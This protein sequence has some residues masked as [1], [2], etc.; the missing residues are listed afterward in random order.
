M[1]DFLIK[2]YSS[3]VGF[4]RKSLLSSI[5]E[6]ENF[7]TE[8]VPSAAYLSALDKDFAVLSPIGWGEVC[9][10]DFE[11]VLFGKLLIKPSM[12][13]IQTWPNIYT[14]NTCYLLNWDF[15]ELT[16]LNDPDYLCSTLNFN[17]IS[18]SRSVYLSSL[19][20]LNQRL[21]DLLNSL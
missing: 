8:R 14:D 4:Q 16:Q 9:Y 1:P 2:A 6:L 10:R 18:H 21:H 11:S 13:H 20:Q 3:S 15:T 12:T 17:K 7:Q 19:L 5:S